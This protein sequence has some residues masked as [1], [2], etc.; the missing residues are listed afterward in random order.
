MWPADSK[1]LQKYLKL[2]LP[3][4][5]NFRINPIRKDIII[6]IVCFVNDL[7]LE[8]KLQLLSFKNILLDENPS[9]Y[10]LLKNH[11]FFKREVV[12]A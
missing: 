1:P 10:N 3:F 6:I 4:L 11:F 5:I 7:I 9:W 2:F 12:T 8:V